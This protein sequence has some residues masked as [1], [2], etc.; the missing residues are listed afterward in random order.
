MIDEETNSVPLPVD[1]DLN[2]ED[3]N[4]N[5]KQIEP[6]LRKYDTTYNIPDV[7]EAKEL[8]EEIMSFAMSIEQ[9]YI[10]TVL[11]RIKSKLDD[12]RQTLV[13]RTSQL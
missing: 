3:H 5:N 8:F 4:E 13:S 10:A 7:K 2:E 6:Q 9:A 1:I 12:L 11:K